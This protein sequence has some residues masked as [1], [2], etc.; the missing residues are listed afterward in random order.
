MQRE[1]DNPRPLLPVHFSGSPETMEV[2]ATCRVVA[3]APAASLGSYVI[4]MAG[5][6][7]D[8]LLVQ[9]LLKETALQRPIRVVPLFET[10]ADLENAGSAIDRL[11]ACQAIVSACR[12]RRK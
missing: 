9:L 7:S 12:G 6:P 3:Q 1:L 2:L 5:A 8:V 11:L 10:L 4:S